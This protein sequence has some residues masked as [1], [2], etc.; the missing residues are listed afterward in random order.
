M[1]RWRRVAATILGAVI[2]GLLFALL[3]GWKHPVMT[4]AIWLVIWAPLVYFGLYWFGGRRIQ[5]RDPK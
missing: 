5:R 1:N 4:L 3:T 2:G